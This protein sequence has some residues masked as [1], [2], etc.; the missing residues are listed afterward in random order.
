MPAIIA[1]LVVILILTQVFDVD[2]LSYGKDFANNIP[3][4]IPLTYVIGAI[5]VAFVLKRI[6]T[7]SPPPQPPTPQ[8]KQNTTKKSNESSSKP[9]KQLEE[10]NL[11]RDLPKLYDSED[12]KVESS[13]ALKQSLSQIHDY[14]RKRKKTFKPTSKDTL[15]ID[16]AWSELLGELLEAT[17]IVYS[18]AEL[19]GKNRMNESRFHYYCQLHFRSHMA[20][21]LCRLKIEEIVKDYS[22]INELIKTLND[23]SNPLRLPKNEYDQVVAIKDVMKMSLE[24]LEE[25]SK[26]LAIQTGII[27]DKIGQECGERGRKWWEDL[28]RRKKMAEE[29]DKK[30]SK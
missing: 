10:P 16:L 14:Q 27:R 26:F 22:K 12:A 30:R 6:F 18:N 9:P 19:V 20:D 24:L 3:E 23:R 1:I 5:V 15:V 8:S 13:A 17:N 11:Q 25:R 4:D 2:I 28:M 7:S 21:Q 29:A